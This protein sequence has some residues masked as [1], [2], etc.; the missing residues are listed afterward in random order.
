MAARGCQASSSQCLLVSLFV[1]VCPMFPLLCFLSFAL[2]LGPPRS[3]V[4]YNLISPPLFAPV[5]F[6]SLLLSSLLFS[7]F[8]LLFS[9]LLCSSPLLSFPCFLGCRHVRCWC[10]EQ[11]C[12]AGCELL[13]EPFATWVAS[14]LLHRL[15]PL[16]LPGLR[17]LLLDG[18][19]DLLLH[20]LRAFLLHEL[21]GLRALLSYGLR[22]FCYVGCG[23]VRHAGRIFEWIVVRFATWAVGPLIAGILQPVVSYPIC[24]GRP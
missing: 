19:G 11:F 9:S 18:F 22:A 23:P 10:Y 20:G 15:R 16:L 24:P 2:S 8:L 12:N 5:I 14:L 7:S 13:C 1:C 17:A 6:S 3:G 21:R 4:E